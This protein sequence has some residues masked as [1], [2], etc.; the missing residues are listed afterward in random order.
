MQ[1][2]RFYKSLRMLERVTTKCLKGGL[3]DAD[4]SL[5]MADD[6]HFADI[7]FSWY[8]PATGTRC[9]WAVR[10][11]RLIQQRRK[12]GNGFDDVVRSGAAEICFDLQQSLLK[13]GGW[14]LLHFGFGHAKRVA[15]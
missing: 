8:R 13:I 4:L 10:R 15:G 1:S 2:N 9:S 11:L 12:V 14:H 5:V 7:T 3:P 6:N